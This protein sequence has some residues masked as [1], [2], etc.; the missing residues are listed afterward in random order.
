MQPIEQIYRMNGQ[1]E[2]Y[3]FLRGR[4]QTTCHGKLYLPAQYLSVIP[5]NTPPINKT[6]EKET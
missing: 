3:A 2:K 1:N 5:E 4:F 6:E